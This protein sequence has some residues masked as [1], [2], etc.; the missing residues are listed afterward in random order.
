MAIDLIPTLIDKFDN[1]EIIR[2]QIEAILVL[3]VVSQMA[4]AVTA[5]KDP[6]LWNFKV[7]REA[8]NAWEQYLNQKTFVTPTVNV[9]YDQ[10]QVDL[11]SSNPTQKQ[12]FEGTFNVDC[13]GFGVN[14]GDGAGG[15]I[16]GDLEAKVN[17]ERTLRLVRNIL[18][19]STN[20]NLQLRP[21]VAGRMTDVITSFQVKVEGSAPVQQVAAARIALAVRYFELSPQGAESTLDF[22]SVDVRREED[23]EIVAEVD[24]DYTV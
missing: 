11:G 13:Y 20:I 10:S 19:S 8:S 16:R 22:L 4:L 14:K 3:E 18:M 2:D 12:V 24:I 7:Y 6:E 17:L 15:Q 23:G 9:W 1:F 5:G 21:V